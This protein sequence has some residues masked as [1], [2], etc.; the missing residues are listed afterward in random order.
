MST[1]TKRST[2]TDARG[3]T[4]VELLVVVVVIGI[5]LAVAVPS[6]MHF[7]DRSSDTA[8]Q[9]SIRNARPAVG[10]Y[11]ADNDGRAADADLDASTVGYEGMTIATLRNFDS[12]ISA[13]ALTIG[14]VSPTSFCLSSTHDGR[15]WSQE[16][17]AAAVAPVACP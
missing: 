12:S 2:Y 7:K 15:V 13:S 3:F 10:A 6:Y 4:L 14:S 9:V 16:G 11:F 1:L 8:A 17:P 5:L